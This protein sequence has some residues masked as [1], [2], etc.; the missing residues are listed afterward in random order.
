MY[1]SV[2][3]EL[4]GT[5]AVFEAPLADQVFVPLNFSMIRV[6]GVGPNF[7]PSLDIIQ[8]ARALG[9]AISLHNALRGPSEGAA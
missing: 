8:G 1:P 4:T 3:R 5:N 7:V 9:N 6:D 2:A